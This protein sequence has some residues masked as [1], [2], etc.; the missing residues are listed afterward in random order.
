MNH[1]NSGEEMSSI[2]LIGGNSAYY[3]KIDITLGIMETVLF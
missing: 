2:G 1:K 3:V